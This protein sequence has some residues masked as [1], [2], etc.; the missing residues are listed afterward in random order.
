[1]VKTQ[2]SRTE[3]LRLMDVSYSLDPPQIRDESYDHV[4]DLINEAGK[5][6]HEYKYYPPDEPTPE[7]W[8]RMALGRII[9]ACLRPMVQERCDELGLRFF[10]SEVAK[11]DGIIGSLDGEVRDDNDRVVAVVEFK[12]RNWHPMSDITENKKYL[13]QAASYCYM[14]GC[15]EAWIPVLSIPPFTNPMQANPQCHI[16]TVTFDQSELDQHWAILLKLRKKHKEN[17]DNDTG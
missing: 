6:T 7:G 10:P 2:S 12:S 14:R 1:M 9:E 15:T 3:E 17:H 5:Y 11:V 16:Y 13:A 8:N 4:S